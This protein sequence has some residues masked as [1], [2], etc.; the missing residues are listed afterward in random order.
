LRKRGFSFEWQQEPEGNYSFYFDVYSPGRA[1]TNE[2]QHKVRFGQLGT[3]RGGG[4][5]NLTLTD[6]QD[7]YK[8][9]R[10]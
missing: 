1:Q 8:E 10:E 5:P 9:G 2:L 6:R 7:L 3:V 4:F